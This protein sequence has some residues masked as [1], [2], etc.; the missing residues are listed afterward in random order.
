MKVTSVLFT[1]FRQFFL[2]NFHF[3]FSEDDKVYRGCLADNDVHRAL[4]NENNSDNKNCIKCSGS[5]CNIHYIAKSQPPSISCVKCDTSE[6]CAFGQNKK[7]ATICKNKVPFGVE[8]SCYVHY[9]LGNLNFFY[10]EWVN[11]YDLN[12][13][14]FKMDVGLSEDVLLTQIN[15]LLQLTKQ[16]MLHFVRNLNAIM[17]MLYIQIVSIV[18]VD[19]KAIVWKS[20]IQMN[21]WINAREHIHMKNVAVIPC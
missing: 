15:F 4:C 18:K 8:E 21:W 7:N 11:S 17:E 3:L 10:I 9:S 20:P 5:G 6:D 13:Y 1:I 16:K 14:Y 2:V 12:V 19:S